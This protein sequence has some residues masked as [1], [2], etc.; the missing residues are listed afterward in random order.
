MAVTATLVASAWLS[1]RTGDARSERVE[2]VV[3]AAPLDTHEDLAE[4]FLTASAGLALFAVT[5]LLGNR[6]GRMARVLTGVGA[7]ALAGLVVRVGHV[8]T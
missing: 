3:A 5:G 2:Q 7:V 1:V 6:P 4:T 8:V